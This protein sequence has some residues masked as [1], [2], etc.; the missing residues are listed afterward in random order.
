MNC[1][2][3]SIAAH[4]LA[5]VTADDTVFEVFADLSFEVATTGDE[6]RVVMHG[7]H[8]NTLF[9][10]DGWTTKTSDKFGCLYSCN[11]DF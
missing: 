11:D 1:G 2:D 3:A 10:E 8:R 9:V 6:V 7:P 5:L 4:E